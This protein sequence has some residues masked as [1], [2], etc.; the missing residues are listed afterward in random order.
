MERI[1]KVFVERDRNGKYAV[2]YTRKGLK[3]GALIENLTL[4]QLRELYGLLKK[5]GFDVFFL[6]K[7]EHLT[8]LDISEEAKV[9]TDDVFKTFRKLQPWEVWE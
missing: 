7:K 2:L 3:D 4:K 6:G 1:L 5:L 8:S 9:P